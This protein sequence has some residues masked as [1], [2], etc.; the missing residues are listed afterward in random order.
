MTQSLPTRI[1]KRKYFLAAAHNGRKFVACG[2]IVQIIK[3]NTPDKINVGFTTT[4]KLGCAVVRNRIRRRLR[5]IC[6]LEFS[7]APRGYNYVFVGRMATLNRSF[8]AL[9]SDA[10]YILRQWQKDLQVKLTGTNNSNLDKNKQFVSDNLNTPDQ[11]DT[12]ERIEGSENE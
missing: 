11:P 4:K 10:R 2:M 7:N 8:D 1:K 5:E 12:K 3:N 9:Q 6:R